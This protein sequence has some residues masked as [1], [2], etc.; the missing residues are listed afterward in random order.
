MRSSVSRGKT[1]RQSYGDTLAKYGETFAAMVEA[2][3]NELEKCYA[4]EVLQK[5][6]G[7]LLE[8][9]APGFKRM[10]AAESHAGNALQTPKNKSRQEQEALLDLME[11]RAM[12]GSDGDDAS[13]A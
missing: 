6:T 3:F 1:G 10:Q 11:L 4:E 9:Y 12:A 8:L 5:S 7:D 2:S 13:N